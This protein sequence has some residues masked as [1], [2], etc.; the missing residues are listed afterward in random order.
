[1]AFLSAFLLF[2]VQPLVGKAILPW[3]GGSPAVWTTAML[4]F[5]VFLVLGYAF[6]ALLNAMSPSP[7]QRWLY[8]AVVIAALFTLPI[9]PQASWKPGAGDDAAGRILLLL[10]VSVGLPY[11]LLAST[12][13][14]VQSWFSRACP[15]R[16]PY[17]LYALSNV[18]SLVAL[19]SY[20]F[21]VEPNFSLATQN[22]I[23]TATFLLAA[24]LGVL[25]ACQAS[26]YA[27]TPG[28]TPNPAKDQAPDTSPEHDKPKLKAIRLVTWL[29]LPA[30]AAVCLLAATNQLCLDVSA[31]PFMWI[32]P[33]T[34]YL[35]S[36]ILCFDRE[37]WYRRS[38]MAMLAL[39]ASLAVCAVIQSSAPWASG[40][41]VS[42]G[43]AGILTTAMSFIRDIRL[44]I[45][46]CR[47]LLY[48]QQGPVLLPQVYLE[49]GIYLAWLFFACMLCHGELFRKRPTRPQ[50][51]TTYYLCIAIG[52]ALGGAFVA[53]AAP[54]IFTVYREWNL[55]LAAVAILAGV[56]I[57]RRPDTSGNAPW[58]PRLAT[59]VGVV[60][61]VLVVVVRQWPGDL[62]LPKDQIVRQTRNFYGVLT[63]IE[64]EP[65]NPDMHG[66]GLYHGRILHG[67]QLLAPERRRTPT[68][69]YTPENG[70]GVAITQLRV[71]RDRPLKIGIVGLGAGTIAAYGMAGDSLHFYEI[72][73]DVIALHPRVFSFLADCPAEVEVTEGDGRIQMERQSPQGFDLLILDAFSGDAVPV[74]LLTR[75]AFA[76][77][78]RH[79]K[80]DGIIVCNISNR[81]VDLRPV[82]LAEA[83]ASRTSLIHIP[84][85][86]ASW[87]RFATPADWVLLTDDPAFREDPVVREN[88]RPLPP[89]LTPIP[90]TDSFSNLF[91]VMGNP[92][93]K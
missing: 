48:P 77:Y 46:A 17:W 7:L 16:S 55:A 90:W 20:P 82:L 21:L 93:G 81:H 65:G 69:Y 78:R 71:L 58:P 41:K 92:H 72:D 30:L 86:R 47:R 19:L 42:G 39:L 40:A 34:V 12:A 52:G 14:L 53:L 85:K 44:E 64:H 66:I 28:P 38:A 26:R 29:G 56:L 36:F 33:L 54:A 5:Q 88:Q 6:A 10:T 15:G 91:A 3:F 87:H 67:F 37:R 61:T 24:A 13:P 35:L 76:T 4:F 89:D 75:E 18:G 22:W 9:L 74:H 50:Q 73:P 60:A 49:G 45:I 84:G 8:L 59:A 62:G 2:Q 57:L 68:T 63:V 80:P 25:L 32:A 27:N 1:M 11:L 43:D 70:G 83:E 51:L 79:L 23:W 31:T